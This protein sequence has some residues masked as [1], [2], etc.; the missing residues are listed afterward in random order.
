MAVL[1]ILSQPDLDCVIFGL[2]HLIHSLTADEAGFGMKGSDYINC[3]GLCQ[4]SVDCS[5]NDAECLH[6]LLLNISVLLQL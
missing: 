4:T 1:V 3:P 5:M 2:Q 6:Q